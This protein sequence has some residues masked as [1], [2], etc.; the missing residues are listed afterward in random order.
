[1]LSKARFTIGNAGLFDYKNDSEL[2]GEKLIGIPFEGTYDL[3]RIMESK[4]V[5]D[6][7]AY[8]KAFMYA[9]SIAQFLPLSKL[10]KVS[11][12]DGNFINLFTFLFRDESF[13]IN[14]CLIT[15][16]TIN[17][18][19]KGGITTLSKYLMCSIKDNFM[20]DYMQRND[21]IFSKNPF[22]ARGGYSTVYKV[23]NVDKKIIY[24]MK[25]AGN[26]TQIDQFARMTDILNSD[27]SL[28]DIIEFPINFES[29][30]NFFIYISKYIDSNSD[31]LDFEK[32]FLLLHSLHCKK[33]IHGDSR[34]PNIL[35]G[36]S[37]KFIDLSHVTLDYNKEFMLND[38]TLLIS[39]IFEYVD[40]TIT[41][42]QMV[43]T[44]SQYLN[45]YQSVED[46]KNFF[47]NIANFSFDRLRL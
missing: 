37:Y 46:L 7:P 30:S 21:F 34:V 11:I 41:E 25:V 23:E 31:Q 20:Y 32:C 36:R 45:S 22:I 18:G 43:Y 39:S 5:L 14:Q 24:A 9:Q 33:I 29:N 6:T 13:S 12:F 8:G 17:W 16:I 27:N 19:Q 42:E 28:K 35:R 26:Q 15:L 10:I 3:L 1:M 4:K 47:I 44:I 2:N 38:W 40:V